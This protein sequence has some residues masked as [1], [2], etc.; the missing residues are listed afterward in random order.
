MEE[1]KVKIGET[2][3]FFRNLRGFAQKEV[4]KSSADH[5][6][7]SR[8]E[9][10]K[11]SVRLEE[12]QEILDTLS[13]NIEEF[14]VFSDFG[15]KQEI[16]RKDF[17]AAAADLENPEKKSVMMRY[18]KEILSTKKKT[19]LQLSNLSSFKAY[20]AQFWPEVETVTADEIQEACDLLA[21]TDYLLQYDYALL[22]N[23]IY[24]VSAKQRVELMKKAF[25]II[26]PK[27]RDAETLKYAYN[28]IPNAITAC[29]QGKQ[30]DEAREYVKLVDNIDRIGKNLYHIMNIK[31]LENLINYIVTGDRVYQKNINRYIDILQ[32]NNFD[33][34]AKSTAEE[35]KRFTFGEVGKNDL[36]V[37]I[38]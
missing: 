2:L 27:L 9:N 15:T 11:R 28:A 23:M 38:M 19:A 5:S 7:Y 20:F 10:G 26:D 6:I 18:Y 30:Y 36:P 17:Y 8:I 3:R 13:V 21:N 29:I 22:A 14:I 1:L 31:Y 16:F 37:G 4:L 12:L 32:E 33:L 25:P 34:I 35:V 24:H